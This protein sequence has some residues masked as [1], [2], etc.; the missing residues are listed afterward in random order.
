MIPQNLQQL[1]GLLLFFSFCFGRTSTLQTLQHAVEQRWARIE[2]DSNQLL[3]TEEF[4]FRTDFLHIT[5]SENFTLASTLL[6]SNM[7]GEAWTHL[8]FDLSSPSNLS[9]LKPRHLWITLPCGTTKTIGFSRLRCDL[10]IPNC[11]KLIKEQY[12]NGGY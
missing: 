7:T 1:L 5:L 4:T 11:T 9:G 6:K 8:T 3:N 10:L 12:Q 2:P